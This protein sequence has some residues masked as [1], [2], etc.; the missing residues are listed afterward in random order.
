MEL[1]T[2]YT[3]DLEDIISNYKWTFETLE[4]RSHIIC[5]TDIITYTEL[6]VLLAIF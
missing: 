6:D 5:P 1:H 2:T 4:S 3:L